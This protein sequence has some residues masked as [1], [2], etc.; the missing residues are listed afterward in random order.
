MWKG[1]GTVPVGFLAYLFV[2][3]VTSICQY[4][5]LQSAPLSEAHSVVSCS[6]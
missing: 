1:Q 5:L 4:L 2:L 6:F 3:Q